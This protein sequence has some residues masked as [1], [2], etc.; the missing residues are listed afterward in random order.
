M[1]D[2]RREEVNLFLSE[3]RSSLSTSGG[4]LLRA[5]TNYSGLEHQLSAIQNLEEQIN[6]YV[7]AEFAN[8]FEL[9]PCLDFFPDYDW[10]DS[11]F[12]SWA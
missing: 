2:R 3:L 8:Q 7:L 5:C 6:P 9:E 10:K 11:S 12:E 4:I 1:L